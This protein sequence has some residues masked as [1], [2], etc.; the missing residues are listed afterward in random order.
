MCPLYPNA[1]IF[2]DKYFA[3]LYSRLSPSVLDLSLKITR[4][5]NP[6]G[7]NPMSALGMGLASKLILLCLSL[8]ILSSLLMNMKEQFTI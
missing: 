7:L 5:T 3:T 1:G 4:D 2:S 8:L 6:L